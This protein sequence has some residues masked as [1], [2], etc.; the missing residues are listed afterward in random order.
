MKQDGDTILVS[1]LNAMGLRTMDDKE[2]WNWSER[3]GLVMTPRR[4]PDSY[5]SK[6]ERA[7]DYQRASPAAQPR[8]LYRIPR[9]RLVTDAFVAWQEGGDDPKVPPSELSSRMVSSRADGTSTGWL[10]EGEPLPPP[11]HIIARRELYEQ[12]ERRRAVM[13]A[14][15]RGTEHGKLTESIAEILLEAD[16]RRGLGS[17]TDDGSP[18]ARTVLSREAIA[19]AKAEFMATEKRRKEALAA[20][21]EA[22]ERK[23][24]E[25]QERTAAMAAKQAAKKARAAR[26]ATQMAAQ[27]EAEFQSEQ[28]S[29]EEEE[30]RKREMEAFRTGG[31]DAYEAAKAVNAAARAAKLKGA[32]GEEGGGEIPGGDR[33]HLAAPSL[34]TAEVATPFPE[35]EEVAPGQVDMRIDGEIA[36]P[37]AALTPPQVVD[38]T[39]VEMAEDELRE[40]LRPVFAR[41]DE[42]R[43]CVHDQSRA[44]PST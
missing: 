16:V 28:E 29:R 5:R 15:G 36:S 4:T 34:T 11:A 43:P 13:R 26:K 21:C 44:H 17:V 38:I 3:R 25:A 24:A 6:K 20:K 10:A 9:D 18:S 8:A 41:F 42:V 14:Q 33:H 31:S 2:R 19:L 27:R 37:A 7:R 12:E 35:S 22:K 39:K 30:A 32:E 1:R 40:R 23:A